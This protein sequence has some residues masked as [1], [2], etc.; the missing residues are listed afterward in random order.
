MN[1]IITGRKCTPRESFQFHAEKKLAKVERLFGADTEAKVTVT[2][3]KNRQI[4]EITVAKH[5]MIFRAEEYAENMNE[6]LNRCVESLVRQI[7]KNKTR[8]EKRLHAEAFNDFAQEEPVTEEDKFEVVRT[9]TVLLKPES[10]EEAILQM[11]LLGHQFYLF[12][13][14]ATDTVNLVYRRKEGG[15][16]VL[17][18]EME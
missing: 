16:G 1:I 6:A 17:E 15:Y 7:R 10:A 9:K 13:N 5:G 14:S 2:V 12:Q 11:N 3:E 8:L 4:V 18:P